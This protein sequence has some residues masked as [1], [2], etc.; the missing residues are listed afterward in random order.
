MVYIYF[1]FLNWK[2]II[3]TSIVC[4]SIFFIFANEFSVIFNFNENY[5]SQLYDER[6]VLNCLRAYIYV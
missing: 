6:E 3:I 2:I 1:L 4:V 5:T